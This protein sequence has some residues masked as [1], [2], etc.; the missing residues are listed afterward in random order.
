MS[1][2]IAEVTIEKGTE[3][4]PTLLRIRFTPMPWNFAFHQGRMEKWRGSEEELQRLEV[5]HAVEKCANLI[6]RELMIAAEKQLGI[7]W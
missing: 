6:A 1:A 7:K 2:N 3:A 5:R 4:V